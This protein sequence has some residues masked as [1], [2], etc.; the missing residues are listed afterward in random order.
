MKNI[1]ILLF[2]LGLVS[3]ETVTESPTDKTGTTFVVRNNT[4]GVNDFDVASYKTYPIAFGSFDYGRNFGSDENHNYQDSIGYISFGENG[5]GEMLFYNQ[6]TIRI[7]VPFTFEFYRKG[8]KQYV[9]FTFTK[10]MVKTYVT[11]EPLYVFGYQKVNDSL[12][13]FTANMEQYNGR[14]LWIGNKLMSE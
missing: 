10:S 5:M 7:H 1:F 11:T 8:G 4:F 9:D 3:C 6:D 2:V 13:I 14:Y 12:W